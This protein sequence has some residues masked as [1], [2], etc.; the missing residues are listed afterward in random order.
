MP[1]FQ[2]DDK[3]HS[4]AKAAE[5][6][7]AVL[8]AWLLAGSWCCDHLTDGRIPT[9]KAHTFAPPKVWKR[10]VVAELL[11]TVDGGYQIRGFLAHN[12]SKAQVLAEREGWAQRQQRARDRHGDST[13]ESPEESRRDVTRDSPPRHTDPVPD[14][15]PN[16]DS[17]TPRAREGGAGEPPGQPPDSSPPAVSTKT[18]AQIGEA[19]MAGVTSPP[20]LVPVKLP[21]GFTTWL[22]FA[23]SMAEWNNYGADIVRQIESGRSTPSPKQRRTMIDIYERETLASVPGAEIA[24]SGPRRPA[25][26]PRG[27]ARA[28]PVVQDDPSGHFGAAAARA[29]V[30]ETPLESPDG[31]PF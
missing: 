10:L 9:A 23:R 28:G 17:H 19:V 21:I 26:G 20:A 18:I 5:A 27:G 15:D 11:E 13:S 3:F 31:R 29:H 6:G 16:P 1:R 22:D 30:A 14:P 7:Y 2:V 8:G 25:H 12:K 24:T 4:H